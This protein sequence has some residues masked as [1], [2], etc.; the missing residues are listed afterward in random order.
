MDRPS[1]GIDALDDLLGRLGV[2]DNVVWQA[3]DPAD[4][5]PFVEAFL[6]TAHGQRPFHSPGR[7]DRQPACQLRTIGSRRWLATAG[8]GAAPQGPHRL[9]AGQP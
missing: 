4:I 7:L 8:P 6:A 9:R 3:P 1:T 5:E 2:G